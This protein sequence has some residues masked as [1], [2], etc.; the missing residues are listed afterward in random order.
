MLVYLRHGDD[1]GEDVYR[2]DRPLNDRGRARAK[3]HARKLIDKLGHPDVVYVSPYRRTLETLEVLSSR[4]DHPVLVRRDPR[5]AQHL[6]EKQ[7]RDP[8]VSPETRSQVVID[9]T[10]DNFKHRV[11]IHVEDVRRDPRRVW[12][13]THQAVIEAAA[14]CLG[15]E[16]SRELDFLDHIILLG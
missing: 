16:I 6:S 7:R 12:C 5:I 8:Q 14:R 13:I 3:K 15:E 9:E 10:P 1:R 2:H 4:F 11:A